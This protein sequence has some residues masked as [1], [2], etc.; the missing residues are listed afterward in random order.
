MIKVG[1]YASG[2]RWRSGRGPDAILCC[3][4][5]L[6]QAL[7]VDRGDAML[8]PF[9]AQ[10]RQGVPDGLGPGGLASVRHAVQPGRPG[11]VELITEHRTRKAALRSAESE[12]DQ[13]RHP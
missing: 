4:Q 6:Q 10:A 1:H 8:D 11:P 12:P 5:V 3:R 2:R 13:R 9:G 7:V